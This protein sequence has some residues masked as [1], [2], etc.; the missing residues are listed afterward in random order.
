MFLFRVVDSDPDQECGRTGRQGWLMT[1]GGLEHRCSLFRRQFG[2]SLWLQ[3]R[4]VPV[5]WFSFKPTGSV[6]CCHHGVVP[7][8]TV[9]CELDS[10]VHAQASCAGEAPGEEGCWRRPEEEVKEKCVQACTQITEYFFI[11]GGEDLFSEYHNLPEVVSEM[12]EV[13][14][15]AKGRHPRER[16]CTRRASQCRCAVLWWWG[17]ACSSVIWSSSLMFQGRLP[18]CPR[19]VWWRKFSEWSKARPWERVRCRGAEC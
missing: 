8:W 14:L 13:I 17:S 5:R 16:F 15:A 6:L 11:S 10:G 7:H 4:I 19:L 9:F 1:W 12:V 3:L 2:S 18:M